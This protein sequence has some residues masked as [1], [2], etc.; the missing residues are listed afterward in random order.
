MGLGFRE[1]VCVCILML[2]A[3]L[4]A[5]G[6]YTIPEKPS[7]SDLKFV[8][9]KHSLLSDSQSRAL[10]LKL[11]HYADTTSTEIV[12]AVIPTTFG[13]DISFLGAKWGQAWGIGQAQEDNGILIILAKDD[14]KVDISTG[15]GV[16]SIISDRDAKRV[17]ERIMIPQFKKGNYY[18]GLDKGTDAL[19]QMLE[20][21]FKGTSS[22]N[23]TNLKP[24]IV[25][26]IFI[27]ILILLSRGTR[28]GRPGS[29]SGSGSLLDVIILSNM[30]RGSWGGSGSSGGSWGGGGGFGGGGSFGGGFGGGGASGGW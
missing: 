22:Q 15:Y 23:A 4:I 25:L 24:I 18:S 6:Q 21:N 8:Y 27:V 14:R 9:N 10:N 29:G 28:P 19:I 7:S 2:C 1:I 5:F 26:I 20:G 16:E 3:P 13:E 12:V 17:I 11:T 30:G